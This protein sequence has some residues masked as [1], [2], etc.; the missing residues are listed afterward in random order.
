VGGVAASGVDVDV[1]VVIDGD[2]D[3]DAA[4][5]LNVV[6]ASRPQPH[7]NGGVKVHVAVK[8]NDHVNVVL[9]VGDHH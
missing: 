3:S 9:R 1:D 2:V 8:V 6:V 5:D 7:V 4:V